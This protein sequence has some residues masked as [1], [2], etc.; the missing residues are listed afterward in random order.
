MQELHL[1]INQRLNSHSWGFK[2][3]GYLF[4]LV[5]LIAGCAQNTPLHLKYEGQSY[6]IPGGV[7]EVGSL[8]DDEH[9][10][11]FKYSREKGEKYLAFSNPGSIEK[12]DCD[13]S[14]FF[15]SVIRKDVAESPCDQR[16]LEAF[17]DSFTS[18][19]DA[20]HWQTNGLDHYY[21]VTEQAGTFIF[22]VLSGEEVIKIDSDFL[23]PEDLYSIIES[24][25]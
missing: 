11:V 19:P 16:S 2:V 12:G 21:F 15:N 18:G 6:Y 5:F 8:G 22:T 24:R 4:L 14:E 23:M 17:R 20:G 1:C 13:Y 3:K 25:D 10:L 9:F 7:E